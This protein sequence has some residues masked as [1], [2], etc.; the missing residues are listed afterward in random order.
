MATV[1]VLPP[2]K[3]SFDSAP[4][5]AKPLDQVG[6][7]EDEI[8]EFL[9]KS[10]KALGEPGNVAIFK[11]AMEELGIRAVNTDDAF[12][13][14]KNTMD[15]FVNEHGGQFPGI[16]PFQQEWNGYKSDWS[17][18]ITTSRDFAT[19]TAAE[20]QDYTTILQQGDNVKTKADMDLLAADLTEFA[21]NKPVGIPIDF[22]D[23][24]LD[25]KRKVDDFQTRFNAY[26]DEQNV[27]LGQQAT[28]L[29]DAITSLQTDL[30]GLD[31]RIKDAT[32]G[33][34]IAS[35]FGIIGAS[36]AGTA[37]A[38][39]A[40]LRGKKQRELDGKKIELQNVEALQTAL[41]EIKA[42]FAGLVPDFLLLSENLGL[43]AD[44]WNSFHN[45]AVT[46][47]VEFEKVETP[48]N[49]P[50]IYKARVALARAASDALTQGLRDY[51]ASIHL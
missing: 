43:F 31:G 49:L 13:R 4:E 42:Q 16:I 22:K 25:L 37:L 28:I 45:E 9:E 39:L 50:A 20:Y 26:L 33:L 17:G 34:E 2:S 32:L 24:F 46:F 35:F 18:Y 27:E 6:P 1:A 23:K 8:L 7:T 40:V 51:A 19:T 47:A 41:G 10:I 30:D 14:V 3:L 29:T 38:V 12:A 11:Q 15:A 21:K 48:A 44:T 36:L 5:T